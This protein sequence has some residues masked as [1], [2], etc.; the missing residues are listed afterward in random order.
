MYCAA[1][2][3]E[4]FS[5]PVVC[6]VEKESPGGYPGPQHFGLLH[7]NSYFAFS[8]WGSQENLWNSTTGN[9][10]VIEKWVGCRT[11]TW[12]LALQAPIWSP[13]S[14]PN[15]W[16]CSPAESSNSGISSG[17]LE[18][19]QSLWFGYSNEEFSQPWS[20]VCPCPGRIA[21]LYSSTCCGAWPL[22]SSC[23][24]GWWEHPEAAV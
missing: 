4:V 18:G 21:E 24:K 2:C 12:I 16:L 8:P 5:E 23:R 3:W 7:E 11:S 15:Q 9:L 19:C 22:A 10:I 6:P 14:S 13:S 1:P 17:N 20:M